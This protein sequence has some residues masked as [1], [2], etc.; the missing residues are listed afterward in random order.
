MSVYTTVK[1]AQLEQFL[2]R[3]SVGKLVSFSPIAAGITNTN[4][5]LDTDQGDFVLTLY[6]HHSD[7]ELEYMLNL[8]QHLADRAVHCSQPV[9][10]RR[11]DF[12]SS[13]N[14]RPAAIIRRLQGVV[15]T[16]VHQRQKEASKAEAIV[17]DEIESFRRWQKSLGAV[18]TILALRERAEAIRKAEVEKVISKSPGLDDTAKKALDNVSM[19]IMNKLIHPPTAALKHDTEDTDELIA[20]IKRLYGLDSD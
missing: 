7:D 2:S 10:D 8:Q 16:N 20:T 3:Y 9:K 14:N 13:L 4:Y 17:E 6:E 19:S 5:R 11:G 12:Y 1:P 18:P 15:E